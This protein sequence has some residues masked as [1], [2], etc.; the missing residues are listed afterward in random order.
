M[1]NRL[2]LVM[3]DWVIKA[4]GRLVSFSS[5]RRT[6]LPFHSWHRHPPLP[7]LACHPLSLLRGELPPCPMP[8]DVL[9]SLRR[10]TSSISLRTQSSSISPTATDL[11]CGD[12]HLYPRRSSSSSSTSGPPPCSLPCRS[13]ILLAV[14]G[15]PPPR[16]QRRSLLPPCY[17]CRPIFLPVT[18]A[19]PLPSSFLA[20]AGGGEEYEEL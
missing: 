17:C 3:C 11:P 14:N 18:S 19:S 12:R 15:T 7:P 16:G 10:Q 6:T 9:V 5:A 13:F 20:V 2:T 1:V 4:C 8:T